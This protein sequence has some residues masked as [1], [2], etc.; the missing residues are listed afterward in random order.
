MDVW[1]YSTYVLYIYSRYLI[2]KEAYKPVVKKDKDPKLNIE[3]KTDH[4]KRQEKDM[5][6]EDLS[7]RKS[8]EPPCKKKK[9]KRGMNK[10]RPR[11]PRPDHSSKLCSFIANGEECARYEK[12]FFGHSIQSYLENKLPDIGDNCIV[13]ERF[14]KCH[15]GINCRFSKSH[16]N[17]DFGNIINEDLFAKTKDLKTKDTLYKDLQIS[18]RKKKYSFPKSEKYLASLKQHSKAVPSS[19]DT[20]SI[21]K[22]CV[23]ATDE[24]VI[25]LR[26]CEKKKVG[27]KFKFNQLNGNVIPLLKI[28]Q[29]H[30][31]ILRRERPC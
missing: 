24:G 19:N 3:I 23:A 30:K 1:Q 12:C 18:L 29:N 2:K 26:P 15:F 31:L 11:Q 28:P 10:K 20:T 5:E 6:K 14:G 27:F 13:Y 22:G 8:E 7:D 9:G 16:V 4:Q 17:E 25:R 21:D